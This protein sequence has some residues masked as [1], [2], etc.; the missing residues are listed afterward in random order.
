MNK[1]KIILTSIILLFAVN[2]KSQI[3][4]KSTAAGANNGTSW[5]NAY[6][7]LRVA[8]GASSSGDE[9]WVAEGTYVPDATNRDRY[10]YLK[11]GV[12]IYGGFPNVGNPVMGDRNFTSHPTIMSGEINTGVNTDNSKRILYNSGTINTTAVLDGFILEKAYGSSG[13]GIYLRNASPTIKNCIIRDNYT[14]GAGAGMYIRDNCSSAT[15]VNCEFSNNTANSEGAGIYLR[16]ANCNPT[17]NLC[18]IDGNHANGHGGGVRVRD[19]SP[20]FNNCEI[21]NNDITLNNRHGGGFYIS[22]TANPNIINCK[23]SNNSATN[24]GGGIY[25]NSSAWANAFSG[26]TLDANTAIGT[27]ADYRGR[28]G[29]MYIDNSCP[30]LTNNIITN[31]IAGTDGVRK[32]GG[33]GAGLYFY[34][35][36]FTPTIS[37]NTITGN[38]ARTTG[39]GTSCGYGGGI[40]FYRTETIVLDN[41]TI[42]DNTALGY[43][44]GI[45]IYQSNP[46]I[47]NNTID[48][49]IINTIYDNSSYGAGIY[50][51]DDTGGGLSPSL[52]NNNI[53]NNKANDNGHANSGSGGGIFIRSNVKPILIK[54]TIENN[55][56]SYRGGGVYI[57]DNSSNAIF[58]RNMIK[59]NTSASGGAVY[60][61]GNI[62]CEFTNNIFHHNTATNGGAFYFRNNANCVFLNNTVT[63]NSATN[64]GAVYFNNNSDLHLKNSIFWGNTATG[65]GNQAYINDNNSNPYFQYCDVEGGK[66]SFA[67]GGSG[68][69]YPG[70]NY[71]NNIELDPIFL[72]GL[73]HI[74]KGT[75]PCIGKGDPATVVG[76][77][78]S[79]EDYDA[80][81]RVRGK[82]DIGAYETNNDPQFITLPYPPTTDNPGDE[83]V[84]M[85]EDGNPTAFSLT[86][87]AI[88]LDDENLIWTIPVAATNGTAGITSSPTNPPNAQSQ[89]ITYTPNANYNGADN[90]TVRVSDGIL[91]DDIQVNVTI[92]A[93]NDEPYFATSPVTTAKATHAYTYNITCGDVDIPLDALTITCP[94]KPAWLTFTDNGDR[95]AILSG[96]PADGDIGAHNVTLQV[97][98]GSASVQ[99]VFVI[100]VS[101]RFIYVPADYPTIQQGINAAVNGDRVIVAAGTYNENIDFSGKEIE[102]IGDSGTPS[103][104]TIDGGGTG[105][106]VTFQS[107]E[108]GAT[109]FEGF[110]L[111]NSSGRL[112]HPSVTTLHAPGSAYYGGGIYCYQSSPKVKNVVIE[113]IS[114]P[115]NNN[116]GS[117]GAAIYIGNVSTLT[118]EGPNTIIQNNTSTQYRGGAICVDDSHLIIDGVAVN[119]VK[120]LNNEGGNYGGG[121]SV[122]TSTL[123]MRR[124]QVQGNSASGSNGR[125][126]GI[127]IHNTSTY[128]NNGGNSVSGNSAT[129]GGANVYP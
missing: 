62:T 81:K 56:A 79:D 12:T 125:G 78:L 67:G 51:Q 23:I 106:C 119:G 83:N 32:G 103:N 123:D 43:G 80:N 84:T 85:D 126:G 45:Y 46:E 41:N 111:T 74:T 101:D 102:V 27:D 20:M 58:N 93:I 122:F 42:K 129:T 13:G 16:Y 107:G 1:I 47:K 89:V 19:C 69:A 60:L 61:Y 82:V 117:S 59:G 3:Y 116:H 31:N 7:D 77:F 28:G 22:G 115:I 88:D 35:A 113:N 55:T 2:V 94:T 17:F 64:G 105:S 118:L 91:I 38:I 4:V 8:I 71:A 37:G 39:T 65:S 90:F 75:S 5:N 21:T 15:F 14:T 9:I 33:Y 6:T 96:T 54:N 36:G 10:F 30:S 53:K 109:L 128:N 25:S 72:D 100:N 68:G 52:T 18:K 95:T 108:A 92:N 44:A 48:N 121:I 114:L 34:G 104:V 124:T 120:I 63:D 49:N 76:D 66:A 40:Y 97:S 110:R 26:N 99:Q 70:G 98:D 11:N 112:G 29:A 73:Y 87:N 86:L 127:Y 50:I 57:T 24:Y